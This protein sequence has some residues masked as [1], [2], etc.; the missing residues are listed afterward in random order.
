MF[1]ATVQPYK[2]FIWGVCSGGRLT[3][4]AETTHGSPR[5]VRKLSNALELVPT[6]HVLMEHLHAQ[7]NLGD[8]AIF[9]S[10]YIVEAYTTLA[11]RPI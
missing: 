9:I 5:A 10:S 8:K 3:L 4:L 7:R 6:L 1:Q 11:C 2:L